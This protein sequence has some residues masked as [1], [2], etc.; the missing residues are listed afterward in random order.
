M[1]SPAG[2]RRSEESPVPVGHTWSSCPPSRWIPNHCSAR[3]RKLVLFLFVFFLN[4]NFFSLLWSGAWKII[5]RWCYFFIIIIIINII[6]SLP[7]L[8]LSSKWIQSAGHIAHKGCLP[9]SNPHPCTSLATDRWRRGLLSGRGAEV[10]WRA[11]DCDGA[12]GGPTHSFGALFS[13]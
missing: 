10:E 7:F 6:N 9:P 13:V 8:W 1:R 12:I 11:R 2:R 3:W 4:L 5:S